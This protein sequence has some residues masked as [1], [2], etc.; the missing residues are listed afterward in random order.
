MRASLESGRPLVSDALERAPRLFLKG[1]MRK[2]KGKARGTDC[3]LKVF[4]HSVQHS[5]LQILGRLIF[6]QG[7][8]VRHAL[9]ASSPPTSRKTPKLSKKSYARGFVI[10]PHPEECVGVVQFRRTPLTQ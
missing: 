4:P 10:V 6:T 5:T 7:A 1:E 8:E 9:L 2:Q 3:V